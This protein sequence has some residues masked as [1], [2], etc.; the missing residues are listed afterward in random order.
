MST[1]INST[2]PAPASSGASAPASTTDASAF[3]LHVN[4][5]ILAL[6]ATFWL[7]R[8]PRALARLWQ[9][10]E[11]TTGHILRHVPRPPP[12]PTVVMSSRGAYLATKELDS[13]VSHTAASRARHARRVDAKGAPIHVSY[14]PHVATTMPLLRPLAAPLSTRI[15]PGFTFAQFMVLIVYISVLVYPTSVATA[16]PFVDLDRAG[17]IALS[18]L[19]LVI[20]FASKNNVLGML[21][22]S[23]YESLS[24]LHRFAA[25]VV[26]IGCNAHGLGYIFKWS[27]AGEFQAKIR[28]PAY[29][30]ALLALTA[31][32]LIFIFSTA[33][34]RSKYYR[35]FLST[36]ITGFSIL[37]PALW[38][39][40]PALHP[41]IYV[42]LGFYGLDHLLRLV[43]TR[44]YTAIVR[45]LPDMGVTRIEVPQL[46]AG[47][48]AGQHV[49]L[50]VLSG[51]MGLTGWAESH[52]FTIASVS[53]SDEGLVLMVKKSG[54]W[55]TRLFDFAK[56]GGYVDAGVG[57]NVNVVLEGPYGGPGH[58]MF[59]SYSAAVFVAGGSGI[60]FAMAAI[61]ELIAQD[62]RGHSRVR[63][64]ELIWTV[65]DP[66]AL[67]PLYPLFNS[68]IERSV[69]TRVRIAVFY[70]RA[71]IG[72]FPFAETAF[73]TTNLQMAPGRPRLATML[74]NSISRTVKLGA[75]GGKDE[76]RMS[77]MLVAVCGPTGLADGV[78]EAIAKIEPL[79]RDQVGGVEVHTEAFG[80]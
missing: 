19:P 72:K 42:A 62:L 45:P 15:A 2:V 8:L 20:L 30:N 50:R 51:A 76:E 73:P 57:R 69:F 37:F 17:W 43:K 78:A 31:V 67:L 22:G 53:G 3:V 9:F 80:F 24:F 33:F 28:Q 59:H 14:P 12:A 55:T 35:I 4:Y 10:S 18:Q 23:S 47:W 75:A 16:G 29:V 60:T 56:T 70:T 38:F 40:K 63:L 49:R 34:F 11:W 52:P 44:V 6:A 26:I 68:L 46:N 7:C 36:H 21:I 58:A 39:H 48:R 71:P 13:E 27:Q 32:N 54:D 74:E 66:A 79:R 77:G 1:P 65:Q 41:Y 61:Q 64:I 5:F 25:R